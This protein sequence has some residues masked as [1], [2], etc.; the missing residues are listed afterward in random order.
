MGGSEWF[1][2]ER[3]DILRLC[4]VQRELDALTESEATGSGG[5]GHGDRGLRQKNATSDP[6]S[7][8]ALAHDG[9]VARIAEL[10]RQREGLEASRRALVKVIDGM[11]TAL[12]DGYADVMAA[13][14]LYGPELAY[15]GRGC[16][17][18]DVADR[19]GVSLR[20]ALRRRSVAADW[21]GD[22]G[23]SGA[24]AGMFTKGDCDGRREVGPVG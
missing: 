9:V 21:L 14:Y 1:E 10:T 4:A 13:Y 11:R 24:M 20:T 16:T 19:E 23:V 5:T 18:Q 3:R 17:W 15:T 2:R 6:V 22:V 7:A 8:A 12:G